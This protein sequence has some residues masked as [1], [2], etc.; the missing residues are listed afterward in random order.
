MSSCA[1]LEI[2]YLFIFLHGVAKS[3]CNYDFSRWRFFLIFPVT[4][5]ISLAHQKPPETELVLLS[6]KIGREMDS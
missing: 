1:Q 6:L 3:E 4:C 5:S 2:K